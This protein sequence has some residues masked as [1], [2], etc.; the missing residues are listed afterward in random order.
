MMGFD[1]S[2]LLLPWSCNSSRPCLYLRLSG[3][4]D[5]EAVDDSAVLFGTQRFGHSV[6]SGDLSQSLSVLGSPVSSS[7]A[8]DDARLRLI[9]DPILRCYFDPVANKYYE[10]RDATA[11]QYR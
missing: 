8:Q 6:G 10:L 7:A 11:R 5:T 2:P 3:H 9:F 1:C 4:D